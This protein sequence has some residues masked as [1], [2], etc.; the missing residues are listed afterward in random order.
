MA[1]TQDNM[2]SLISNPMYAQRAILEVLENEKVEIGTATNPF[3]NLIE[4]AVA[5]SSSSANK[6]KSMMRKNFPSL[7]TTKDDLLAF[8]TD[9]DVDGLFYTPGSTTLEISVQTTYILDAY[10]P[11]NANYF[12][13]TIPL[14]TTVTVN[15]WTLTFLNDII[16][17]LYKDTNTPYVEMV[18]NDNDIAIN[19]VS[20]LESKITSASNELS[21]ITFEVPIKQLSRTKITKA[22]NKS[23][24]F[25]F[26][27]ELKDKFYCAEV[28]YSSIGNSNKLTKIKQTFT[29]IYLDPYT[30]QVVVDVGDNTVNFKIPSVYITNGTI[31]GTITIIVYETKGNQYLALKNFTGDS[32]SYSY[33][34]TSSSLSKA[35]MANIP[36]MIQS[37]HPITGGT[38][39]ISFS[40]LRNKIINHTSGAIN[41]PITNYQIEDLGTSYNYKITQLEDVITNRAYGAS[42]E[43]TL[44]DN[45]TIIRANPDIFNNTAKIALSE[46]KT[47]Y[48]DLVSDSNFVIKANTV[49]RENNGIIEVVT[50]SELAGIKAMNASSKI[51]HFKNNKYF[52]TPFTYVISTADGVTNSS[53]FHLG[54]PTTKNIRIWEL[55]ENIQEARCYISKIGIERLNNGY[56]IK[57]TVTG[58]DGYANIDQEFKSLQISIKLV[59]G[60]YAHYS[61]TYKSDTT[62][63]YYYVDILTE[64][65]MHNDRLT[66]SSTD[67]DGDVIGSSEVAVRVTELTTEAYLY[68]YTTDPNYYDEYRSFVDE[69]GLE[70]TKDVSILNKSS[71]DITFGKKIDYLWNKIYSDYTER[72][73]RTYDITE[74]KKYDVDVYAKDLDGNLLLTKADD[75][76]ITLTKLFSKG[77][78]VLDE[79]GQKVILHS[80]GDTILDSNGEPIIDLISGILRYVDI[81]MLEYEFS[82]V[83]SG[84]NTVAANFLDLVTD[85]F[86][87]ILFTDLPAM[88]KSL[89]ERTT[90]YYKASRSTKPV[91]INTGGTEVSIDYR[92]A[93][94]VTLTVPDTVSI[95]L[96]TQESIRA[97]IGN[98]INSALTSSTIVLSDIATT[99]K[100]KLD[101]NIIDVKIKNLANTDTSVINVVSSSNSLVLDKSIQLSDAKEM[102]VV[103][104]ITLEINKISS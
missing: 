42:K 30:P 46:Y 12:E 53:I 34:D 83:A 85:D 5:T 16:I 95:D 15:E 84:T 70:N 44:A 50:P 102:Y 14:G 98:I 28:Y 57:A 97:T 63:P 61:F 82:I 66:L 101:V 69:L 93:P 103:Y 49:F 17:R 4:A 89:L 6:A 87:S 37:N 65:M 31:S 48:P 35:A 39:G 91:T 3:L 9:T 52:Y 60:D 54:K 13:A 96:N 55:N 100:N 22:V 38:D 41:M 81:L 92:V 99:I 21:F 47:Y 29:D 80:K 18:P 86:E 72:K 68:I 24:G 74:Y 43:I 26:T 2:D 20:I 64:D 75:N 76:K 33:G 36:I 104:N 32:Y 79:Q 23:S 10:K 40:E 94:T 1:I 45:S 7:A 78:Y 8:I 77:D 51:E 58:N 71:V 88:N 19:N 11:N 73:Y 90:I 56:R 67:E 62:T 25:D 59:T 27:Y